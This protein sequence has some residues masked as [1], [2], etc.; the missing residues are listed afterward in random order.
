MR[1]VR[2]SKCYAG[3]ASGFASKP[4]GQARSKTFLSLASDSGSRGLVD[5]T[6]TNDEEHGFAPMAA[7]RERS[8]VRVAEDVGLAGWGVC[9]ASAV[10]FSLTSTPGWFD[11]LVRRPDMLVTWVDVC[12]ALLGFLVILRRPGVS[13]LALLC[14]AQLIDVALRLPEVPNHRMI[15]ALASVAFLAA[16]RRRRSGDVLDE[17]VPVA[18]AIVVIVY[19][20]A[21]FAKLNRDFLD[22]A[23]SCAAQFYDSATHWW[24]LLPDVA[25]ARQAALFGTLAVEAALPLGLCW[26]RSRRTAVVLGLVFHFLLALDVTHNFVNFSAVMSALLVLYLPRG[27]LDSLGETFGPSRSVRTMLAAGLLLVLVSGLLAVANWSAYTIVYCWTRQLVWSVYAIVLCGAAIV[28][29]GPED[30]ALRTWRLSPAGA[31]IIALTLLNGSG[32]Y[33]GLK[34]RT[35][36]DMYSNLRVEAERSNHLLVPRS[37]DL[38]GVLRDRVTILDTNDSRLRQ[39]F[40]EPGYEITYFELASLLRESPD[41]RVRYL[42]NGEEHEYDSSHEDSLEAPSVW[43]RKFLAFRALGERSRAECLW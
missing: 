29:R 23:S 35:A 34:T 26:K 25:L 27:F 36:F 6:C 31:V 20:F 8:G 19:L 2:A 30:E 28:W 18:R 14:A 32:P 3:K 12:L 33:L 1:I 15:L 13:V 17:F 10:L 5:L 24:L 22:P 41:A 7:E 21:F 38:L 42:R 40:A 37:L 9:W 43:L 39:R 11:A 16:A 4:D